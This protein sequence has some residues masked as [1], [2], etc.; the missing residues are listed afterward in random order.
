[1]CLKFVADLRRW[2]FFFCFFSS[3]GF[4]QSEEI[5]E[6]T[7]FLCSKSCYGRGYVNK[8]DSIA[9]DFIQKTFKE[10]GLLPID[11]S[12]YQFFELNVNTFPD[13]CQVRINDKILNPGEDFIVL[14]ESGSTKGSFEPITIGKEI[15][16]GDID[17][18]Y[19]FL[20]KL[21]NDHILV[22]QT[23]EFSSKEQE[24]VVRRR[25]FILKFLP[26]LE[27][28]DEKFIW[29]VGRKSY[30]NS[31]IQVHSKAFNVSNVDSIHLN[32]RNKFIR[33]YKSKN[34]MGMLPSNKKNA[35]NIFITAHYDHLGMMG[36]NCYFPGAN[37]NASGNAMLIGLINQ[38]KKQKK[39]KYNYIFVA[40]GGEEAGLVGSAHMSRNLIVPKEKMK[41]LLNLD[42][43][44]SGEDGITVV[45]S[46]LFEREFKLLVKLNK[47]KKCI[48]RIKKRGPA[49]NSDHYFFTQMGIPSFF[50][51]T[52][53]PNKNYHDV[54]DVYENLSFSKYNQL[55]KLLT[56]F[57]IKL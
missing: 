57:L 16:L 55:S 54:F 20:K 22:I 53:G 45:N 48:K 39:R 18:L 27:I 10:K 43:F 1:M 23:S 6:F 15:L 49:A 29:S 21:T 25:K 32:I 19:I 34:V 46:T 31:L 40:F 41:F 9:A 44:G 17:E 11:N 5:K 51:Y 24:N 37:D 3:F 7:R 42:I 38:L 2:I 4:G 30:E 33:S 36:S 35:K 47:K 8:G 12:F 13:S 26:I 52:E 50:I 14:P 28:T 56:K